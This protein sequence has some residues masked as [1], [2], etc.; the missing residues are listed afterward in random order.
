MPGIN[1]KDYVTGNAVLYVTGDISF[2]PTDSIEL[3]P[4]AP[5][6]IYAAGASTTINTVV[7]PNTDAGRAD[8]TRP[9]PRSNY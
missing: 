1:G 5:L 7:N 3:A 4:G 9:W 2:G 6:K 8:A